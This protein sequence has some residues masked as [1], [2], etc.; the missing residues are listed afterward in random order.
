[1][2]PRV[3]E[4]L[5]LSKDAGWVLEPPGQRIVESLRRS[6][7]PFRLGQKPRK[8]PSAG[9]KTIGYPL[10]AKVVSQEVLHKSD[11][12]GVGRGFENGLRIS[13]RLS[14]A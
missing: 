6:H 7:Q 13:W 8:R 14:S 10:V 5:N 9:A 11:V 3:A 2:N 1:M 12:G 4:I